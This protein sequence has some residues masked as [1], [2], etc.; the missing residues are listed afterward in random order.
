MG[1]TEDI[2]VIYVIAK[3][4]TSHLIWVRSSGLSYED[5]RYVSGPETL[6]GVTSDNTY[7]LVPG[8]HNR[9]NI[10]RIMDMVMVSGMREHNAFVSDKGSVGDL[11]RLFFGSESYLTHKSYYKLDTPV[12]SRYSRS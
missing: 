7:V 2:G 9:P 3:S 4:I 11:I 6:W 8:Y 5:V 10:D 12:N 1:S